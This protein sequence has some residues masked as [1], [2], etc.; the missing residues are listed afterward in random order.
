MSEKHTATLAGI[1]LS[2]KVIGLWVMRVLMAA[3]FLF[4]SY[5]KLTS[6]PMMVAEFDQVGLGQ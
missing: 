4:A 3:L 6:Q 1:G 5:M 2:P